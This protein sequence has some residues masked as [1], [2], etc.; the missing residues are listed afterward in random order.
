ML[1]AIMNSVIRKLGRP[2]Y[3]IDDGISSLDLIE[4]IW[5][6][7]VQ[8]LRGMW[9]RWRLG[10]ARGVLFVGKGVNIKHKRSVYLGRNC[11]IDDGVIINALAR[12]GMHFGD[13]LTLRQ[14][15]IIDGAGVIRDI[16]EGLVVGDRVGISQNCFVQVRGPVK[17]GSDVILGPYVR[18]FSENHKFDDPNIPIN[19]QGETRTGVVIGDGVW[20]GSG[21]TILDGVEIGRNSVIAAG[22]VVT[23]SVPD[24]SVVAGIPAKIIKSLK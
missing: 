14:N 6:R 23:K 17:I 11:T 16:G 4:I 7:A 8:A 20:I 13:N 1:K 19:Q 5:G 22:S 12:K 21:A 24:Y 15:V 9:L 2:D 10:R 3:A 18:I